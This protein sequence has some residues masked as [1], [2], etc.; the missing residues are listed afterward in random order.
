[1]EFLGLVAHSESQK[2]KTCLV[3]VK[4]EKVL[5]VQW[6]QIKDDGQDL[7]KQWYSRVGPHWENYRKLYFLYVDTY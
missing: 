4:S 1:M 2:W 5:E 7:R 6:N 3:C